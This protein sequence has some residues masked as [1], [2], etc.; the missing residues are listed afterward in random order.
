M[1][2]GRGKL[3]ADR[4]RLGRWGEKRGR[5]FLENLGLRTLT[6]NFSCK[7]GELDIIM[8]DRDET[9]VFVE[10]KTRADERFSPAESAITSRKK[11]RMIR[12]AHYFLA[13]NGLQD[14]PCR[15][16]VLIIVLGRTGKPEIRH[17]PNAFVP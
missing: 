3:L 9:L 1:I 7:T 16:D 4:A 17:Y 11:Q 13:S 6:R 8:V 15:F 14:R 2:L 10:I 5:R 12:A